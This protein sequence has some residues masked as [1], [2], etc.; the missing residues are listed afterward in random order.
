MELIKKYDGA[1]FFVD[2]LGMS[3]LTNNH[4]ALKKEDYS[5]WLDEHHIK[6]NPQYLAAA[7]LAKFREILVTL[8][9][10]FD[11][12]TIS[13]LSDCAFIWSQN[14]SD[15]V[16]FASKFMSTAIYEGL[17]CRGGMAYG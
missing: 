15:V 6:H 4:I 14:I 3:A 5:F 10:R 17:L 16:L 12:V 2:M 1:V 13:Q 8:S 7:L 9:L 11:N